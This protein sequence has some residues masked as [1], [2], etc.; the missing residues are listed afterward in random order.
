MKGHRYEKA[1]AQQAGQV[2]PK[3]LRGTAG[4]LIL[5]LINRTGFSAIDL[6]TGKETPFARLSPHRSFKGGERVGDYTISRDGIL[7]ACGAI[8][9][10]I[11]IE[12]VTWLICL[13]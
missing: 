11:Y 12:E 3:H 7:F 9:R 5:Y 2:T 13:I 4:Y 6:L 8:E 10:A 1:L